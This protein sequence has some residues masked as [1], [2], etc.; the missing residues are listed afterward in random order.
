VCV[1]NQR[2]WVRQ[3]SPEA[4]NTEPSIRQ[5]RVVASPLYVRWSSG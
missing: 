4:G 2:P 3:Q 5:A 1:L